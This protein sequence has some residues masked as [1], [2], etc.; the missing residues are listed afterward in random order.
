MFIGE[1]LQAIVVEPLE[2]LFDEPRDQPEPVAPEPEPEPEHE[3]V[4]L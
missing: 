4:V 3:C 2:H 1:P